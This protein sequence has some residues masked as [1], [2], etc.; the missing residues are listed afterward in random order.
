MRRRKIAVLAGGGIGELIALTPVFRA[1]RVAC[2]EARVV[3]L[4]PLELYDPALRLEGVHRVA[5][6]PPYPGLVPGTVDRYRIERFL[7]EQRHAKYD[8][9]LQLVDGSE[10]ANQFVLRLGAGETAGCREPQAVAPDHWIPLDPDQH[11]TLRALD[12]LEIVGIPA[13]GSELEFPIRPD[14]RAEF[15][16]AFRLA[17][18]S[19]DGANGDRPSRAAGRWLAVHVGGGPSRPWPPERWA[20]AVDTLLDEWDLAGVLL[21]ADDHEIELSM[22]YLSC[23][24]N[25]TRTVNLAG[26]LSFGGLAAAIANAALFLSHDGGP[27]AIAWAVGTPSVTTYHSRRP[28]VAGPLRRAYHRPVAL[29][30]GAEGNDQADQAPGEIERVLAAATDLLRL[31]WETR[32]LPLLISPRSDHSVRV[33][34]VQRLPDGSPLLH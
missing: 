24:R 1:L 28:N 23:T 13:S 4:A 7:E 6:L 20:G 18:N 14:D 30:P 12:V 32:D 31:V 10:A 9:A 8:L 22:D 27:A 15:A 25:P 17:L 11:L 29:A 34:T 33:L 21:L 3:L 5:A 26:M 2:P 16:E 19:L